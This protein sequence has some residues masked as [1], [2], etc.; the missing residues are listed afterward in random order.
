MLPGM[1]Y[2]TVLRSPV[3]GG[4]V[5]SM[6]DNDARNVE[7][8]H[9]VLVIPSAS[10]STMVGGFTAGE[11]VAGVADSYWSASKAL[12]QI[13]VQWSEVGY[14]EV[15]SETIFSQFDK[16]IS[17]KTERQADVTQGDAEAIFAGATKIIAI[18]TLNHQEGH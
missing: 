17:A 1:L 10:Y 12:Q 6:Q 8:V 4:K 7:G 9:E 13:D 15:S 2:A 3:P 11:T 18:V 14:E 5:V 16:D